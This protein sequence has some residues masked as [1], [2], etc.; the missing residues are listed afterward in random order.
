MKRK[1]KRGHV[2]K[3]DFDYFRKRV[4]FW[5]KMLGITWYSI[6]CYL[7]TPWSPPDVDSQITMA[8][9]G[10]SEDMGA[11]SIT[12]NKDYSRKI[13]RIELD[14]AAFHEV[15]ELGYFGQLRTMAMGTYN[16]YEVERS[17]HMVV[18]AAESTIFHALRTKG[19]K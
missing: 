12:L 5:K 11:A 6:Q 17:T 8:S 18:R 1:T 19:I 13:P 4:E 7:G 10:F 3:A 2:T 9:Y 14:E 16:R 15:L